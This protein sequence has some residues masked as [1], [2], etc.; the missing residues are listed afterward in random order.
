MTKE[1]QN[2]RPASP[3]QWY[4]H[5][6]GKFI[7]VLLIWL[8]I[9]ISII[10]FFFVVSN[11]KIK[12]GELDY[13]NW[14]DLS[15]YKQDLIDTLGVGDIFNENSSEA[16]NFLK[17]QQV[18]RQKVET[19]DDPFWGR[20][21]AKVVIVE[22]SDFQ[23][24]YCRQMF[25]VVRELSNIYKDK[26]KFIFRDYPIADAHPWALLAAQAAECADDQGKF[27]FMHDKL[28]MN[29]S[30]LDALMIESLAQQSGLG[31][32]KFKQCLSSE[33]YDQ[34]VRQDFLTG[35]E[36]GVKGTPSFFING[37]RLQGIIP[38]EEFTKVVEYFLSLEAD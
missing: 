18:D 8:A 21:D 2:V 11:Q 30:R 23:C 9:V 25:P 31:M 20:V 28:F 19:D 37:Y 10:V 12:T 14:R 34:E 5:W 26:V 24:P 7:I 4:H 22:F 3:E 1:T 17:V 35:T 27:L 33:K 32:P 16:G 6:W 36:L 38:L 13:E 29:Q 15:G